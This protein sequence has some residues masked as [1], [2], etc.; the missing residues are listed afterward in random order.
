MRPPW[1]KQSPTGQERLAVR[2]MFVVY[3]TLIGAGLACFL[4]VA[5]LGR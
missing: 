1:A 2:V 4:A 3:L 5:L